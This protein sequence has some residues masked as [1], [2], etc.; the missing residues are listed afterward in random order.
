MRTGPDVGMTAKARLPSLRALAVRALAIAAAMM[1]IHS[2]LMLEPVLA[3]GEPVEAIGGHQSSMTMLGDSTSVP[4]SEVAETRHPGNP[5]HHAPR[6]NDRNCSVVLPGVMP[7]NQ[8]SAPIDRD[9]PLAPVPNAPGC[10]NAVL[11]GLPELDR[12]SQDPRRKRSLLQIW[13]V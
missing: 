9:H 6:P 4:D 12:P 11:I 1:L 2:A 5:H 8:V 7:G 3:H 10:A 13:R